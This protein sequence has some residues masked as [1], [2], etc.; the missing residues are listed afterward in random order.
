PDRGRRL[1]KDRRRP[2][3]SGRAGFRGHAGDRAAAHDRV[4]A[5]VCVGL[6]EALPAPSRPRRGTA[7][8]GAAGRRGGS[9]MS[10]KTLWA[11]GR[12]VGPVLVLAVL[13]WRLG[14]GPFL[15]GIRSVDAGALAAATGIAALCTVCCAWRWK[16]VARGLGVELS[17]PSAVA[18]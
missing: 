2:G 10:R 11:W 3:Q 13:V 8:A 17:L 15:A 5:A 9:G 14:T 16:I 4:R 1:R 7:T 12:V 6:R 18:A